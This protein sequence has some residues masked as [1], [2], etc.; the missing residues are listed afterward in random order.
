MTRGLLFLILCIGYSSLYAQDPIQKTLKVKDSIIIDTLSI[1]PFDFKVRANKIELD[2][3][4]YRVSYRKAV[5]YP[6]Q[7]LKDNFAEIDIVYY[8]LPKFLTNTYQLYDKKRIVSANR[9][10]DNYFDLVNNQRK[11]S[12]V[13]I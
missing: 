3:T 13:S 11:P 6:T 4:Y 7:K 1:S 9:N 5:L 10:T 8:A 2:S 12:N